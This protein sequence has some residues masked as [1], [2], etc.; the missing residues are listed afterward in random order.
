MIIN[1]YGKELF[2]AIDD[3]YPNVVYEYCCQYLAENIKTHSFW[4]KYKELFCC[5][6]FLESEANF[7]GIFV[8]IMTKDLNC[9]NYLRNVL[10]KQLA[11]YVFLNP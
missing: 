3:I 5:A 2:T 9:Y 10:A 6:A 7:D 1:D 4:K 8:E 11:I